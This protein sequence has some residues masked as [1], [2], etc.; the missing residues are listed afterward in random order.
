MTKLKQR[1]VGEEGCFFLRMEGGR[2]QA[3]Y[4]DGWG[5]DEVMHWEC[6]QVSEQRKGQ[7]TS[8]LLHLL[9]K[10]SVKLWREVSG[11]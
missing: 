8:I 2:R 5:G 7:S 3:W 11:V 9:L 1:K 4:R 6:G 10:A